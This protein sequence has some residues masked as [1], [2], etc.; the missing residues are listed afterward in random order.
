MEGAVV[1]QTDEEVVFNPYW[2]KNPEMRWEVI[3]LPMRRVKRVEIEPH[4]QVEIFRRLAAREEG[5]TA[6]LLE[7]AV[8]AG[9]HKH[10]AHARMCWALALAE[11]PGNEVA[12]KGLGGASKWKAIRR[13]NVHL[14]PDLREALRTYAATQDPKEREKQAAVLKKA[15]FKARLGNLERYRRSALAPKGLMEDRPLSWGC[16]RY[17]GAVYTLFVP[18]AYDPVVPW[19]LIIGLHGGGADGKTGDEV[20]GS[21]RSAMNFYRGPAAKHGYIVACPDALRAPWYVAPN[22]EMVRALVEELKHLYNVDVD[23]IYMTGHSMGG[24][25]TWALGPKMAEDLA[26][27]SP[28]AGGGGSG[29]SELVK[30]KTPIFIYHS[31]NDYVAVGPD[32]NAARRLSDTDL[33]FVYTELPGKGHGFPD[34]IQAELFAF[35]GPRRRHDPGH[36]DTWPRSSFAG[37]TTKAEKTYLGDPLAAIKGDVEDLDDWIDHLRLGGGRGV[38]AADLLGETKPDGAV[39]AVAKVLKD[40][41]VPFNGRACAARALGRL[42]DPAGAKA[43]R[44]AVAAEAVRD[45]SGVAVAAA[46]ALVALADAEGGRALARGVEAWTGYYESKVSGEGMRFSDWMRAVP[47][48]AVLVDAWASLPGT[49]EATALDRSVVKRLLVPAHEVATSARV[50]QD[51]SAPR[52]AL[53]KAVARAYVAWDASDALWKR[54]REAVRADPKALAAVEGV[55]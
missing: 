42:G 39:A 46:R 30:T 1:S 27:I 19:P 45:Q 29:I 35:L 36:K 2:S 4:P 47:T 24:F 41:R 49:G 51:P 17:P 54:L 28:M 53:A 3:R 18:E 21:G 43:L 5:D 40:A 32:R 23:R 12:L 9:E 26:A 34:S 55:R 16:D 44:K 22:E 52:I 50:P 25:G 6:A 31:D 8:F 37:K 20:F 14:D 15:G 48:L 10:K 33:D 13:G 7:I 38:R 11:D